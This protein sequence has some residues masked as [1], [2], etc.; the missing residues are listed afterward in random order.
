M[1]MQFQRRLSS[2]TTAS[3]SANG[4]RRYAPCAGRQAMR[5]DVEPH[6]AEHMIDAHRAGVAH[7]RAQHLRGT[8]RSGSATRPC[9]LYGGESPVLSGGIELV[10]RRADRQS[11]QHHALVHPGVGAAGDR[12]RPRCRDRARSTF[13][14]RR[15][16][17]RQRSSWRSAFHCRN[18]WKPISSGWLSRNRRS[19]SSLGC[20]H[21][22]GHSGHAPGMLSAQRF[23]CGEAFERTAA[24][25]PIGF[26]VGTARCRCR[27]R[28]N[29]DTPRA[30]PAIFSVATAG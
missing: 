4:R 19:A 29:S 30:M 5:D 24:L 1:T 20:R 14:A 13:R 27:S 22:S 2:A 9:G 17:S 28:Q 25:R 16:M 3:M 10:G 8:A 12:R 11:A 6:Q 21:G 18:S 7:G 23:E 26:E 15:A